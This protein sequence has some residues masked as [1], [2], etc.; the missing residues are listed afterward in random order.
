MST[1]RWDRDAG[2]YLID[3]EPC[4]RDS[5]G[6]PTRHCTARRTCSEHVG[7]REL[8]CPRCIGRTRMDIRVIRDRAAELW[9]VALDAG[10]DS[11][12]ANLTGP[13]ADH[14]VFEARRAIGREWIYANIHQAARD[15]CDDEDC[16]RR[17]FKTDA[18][19]RWHKRGIENALV[20]L[21]PE[22]DEL[23]PYSVLCR[24]QMMLSEDYRDQLPDIMGIAG[25]ADY[26]ERV[27]QRIAHDEEQDFPLFRR[28]IR[29]CRN[30]LENVLRDGTAPE[31]GAPCPDCTAAEK[32][33]NRMVRE[34]GHW[35]TEEDCEQIHYL[36][37]SGDRWVCPANR[38][39]WMTAEGYA[40]WLKERGE[41]R[42]RASA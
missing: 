27:L 4:R 9:P 23:H 22:D 40:E 12:A 14:R 13:A 15:W 30:H 21:L 16:T 38:A 28:E 36:D 34:Y 19:N 39:H 6:D 17:H 35:C 3:G 42:P 10:V 33:P 25:A 2:D 5:Y 24:W 32:K 31:R 11:E 18:G 29:R 7:Y 8:T 1:C 20:D 41:T 37:D 26:L